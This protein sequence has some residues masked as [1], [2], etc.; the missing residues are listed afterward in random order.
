MILK[1]NDFFNIFTTA[2]LHFEPY[3]VTIYTFTPTFLQGI[4]SIAHGYFK[5]NTKTQHCLWFFFFTSLCKNL[6]NS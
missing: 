1:K 5:S 6:D 4:H 2:L 3:G